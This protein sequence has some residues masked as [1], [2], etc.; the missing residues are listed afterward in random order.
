MDGEEVSCVVIFFL[1]QLNKYDSLPDKT[2]KTLIFFV[3]N[4]TAGKSA[5]VNCVLRDARGKLSIL[6]SM[7]N[8]GK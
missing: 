1:L 2:S 3:R 8:D 4:K 6:R 7:C 5:N